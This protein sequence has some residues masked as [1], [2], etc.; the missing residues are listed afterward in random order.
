MKLAQALVDSSRDASKEVLK[1]VNQ[2]LSKVLVNSG[3]V[4]R[5]ELAIV[6]KAV[7]RKVH[8]LKPQKKNIFHQMKAKVWRKK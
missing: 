7:S 1:T 3:L 2:E 6:K 5:T 4:S 8:A